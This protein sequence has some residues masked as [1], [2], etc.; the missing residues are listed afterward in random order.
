M[1][2]NAQRL[3][4]G[5]I[6]R[7]YSIATG[8]TDVHLALVDLRTVGLTGAPAERVLELCSIAC[9][10]NTVPG[11]KS[12]LNP[13]GIRLGELPKLP[14]TESEDRGQMSQMRFSWPYWSS[15]RDQTTYATSP[16]LV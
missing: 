7:G 2:K 10:K 9:N 3:C 15:I 5:L 14:Y 11:D 16:H 6:S 4:K 13:S 8:G 12:A 1:I